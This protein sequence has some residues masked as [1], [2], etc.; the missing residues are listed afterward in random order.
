LDDFAHLSVLISIVLGLGMTNLLM[1]LARVV[2]L[3][4]L[5]KIYWPSLVWVLMLLIVHVQTWWTM[6]GL[7]IVETWSF[8][9]FALVLLQPILLFFVSALALP[10]FDRDTALDMRA[11]YFAH[12][13]WFFAMAAAVPLVSLVRI[14][15]IFGEPPT[16]IDL[17]FHLSFIVGAAAGAIFRAELLHKALAPVMTGQFVLYTALLFTTL[18]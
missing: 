18:R 7:R 17:A 10:D 11:N 1:G 13:R 8:F 9:S 14:F 15:V 5:V 6:F 2:Q 4:G 16:P 12:A 3:R